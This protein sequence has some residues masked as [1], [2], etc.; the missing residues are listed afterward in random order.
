MNLTP[1]EFWGSIKIMLCTWERSLVN[2]SVTFTSVCTLQISMSYCTT[3]TLHLKLFQMAAQLYVS[4]LLLRVVRIGVNACID[5]TLYDELFITSIIEKYFHSPLVTMDNLDRCPV[6]H[7]WITLVPLDRLMA[8]HT[9]VRYTAWH[10]IQSLWIR[11]RGRPFVL[12]LSSA[13]VEFWVSL[14][15]IPYK[16]GKNS[17]FDWSI[18][19]S[20]KILSRYVLIESLIRRLDLFL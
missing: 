19:N 9:Q 8:R 13:V 4:W 17:F 3:T 11:H 10:T 2:G 14:N 7:S 16:S 6:V 1:K 18:L 5:V 20:F 15:S 12:S